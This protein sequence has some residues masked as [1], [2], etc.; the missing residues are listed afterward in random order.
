MSDCCED[1]SCAIEELRWRQGRTLKIVLAINAMMFLVEATAGLLAHSIALLA[2][3][4]DMLGDALVY[5]FS[6]YVIT[7][8]ARWQAISAIFKGSIMALFGIFVL[9]EAAH[10]ILYP[11][12]P[13]AEAIGIIGVA[14][15]L[16]NSLCLALLWRHQNDDINM[17]SVWLCS[18]NDI[19]ANASVLLAAIGVRLT[20]S[21]APDVI[22]GILI[23]A[24]FLRSAI[25][26]LTRARRELKAAGP[27]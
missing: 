25:H 15:L 23:A 21:G 8:G 6:L 20:G 9:A 5:S 24:V 2:D 22:V 1:K 18:R 17:H 4:L 10:K 7:R 3:S 27:P 13:I 12:T 26:V 19:I 14:A 11:V 16:T